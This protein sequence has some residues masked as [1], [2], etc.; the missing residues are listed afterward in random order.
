MS[1]MRWYIAAPIFFAA[2]IIQTALL[3]RFELWGQSP[4][5]LLCMVCVFSFLYREPYGLVM[6]AVFGAL[7]D[8]AT[9]W[10]F[11]GEAISFVLAFLVARPFAKVFNHEWF[12]PE[13]F[14]VAIATPINAF[15]I[16]AMYKLVG[17]P[18]KL[19]F[20]LES[21]PALIIMHCVLAVLLHFMFVRTV[22][23]HGIDRKFYGEILM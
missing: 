13:I 1:A 8:V 20:V 19:H 5:L 23:R 6:G 16:W 17:S 22:I 15:L 12:L 4:N 11:G 9:S 10:Y 2:L 14:V 7:L 3:Y 18:V 21:L